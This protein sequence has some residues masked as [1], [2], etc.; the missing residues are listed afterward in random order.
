MVRTFLGLGVICLSS[1]VA[2][3]LPAAADTS[4]ALVP[5]APGVALHVRLVHTTQTAHGSDTTTNVFTL[6]RRSA[7]IA[8]I[9][10]ANP[11]GTPNLSVL[12]VAA[13]GT[14][15]LA[16][17]PRGAAADADV[18]GFLDGLNLAIAATHGSDAT[19]KA[20]WTALMPVG[21]VGAA[22]VTFEAVATGVA[23]LDF[24]GNG[25]T[26]APPPGPAPSESPGPDASAM[27][28]FPGGRHGGFGGGLPGGEFGGGGRNG[29]S[30]GQ[31]GP[32]GPGG[33]GGY[34]R[35]GAPA[36]PATVQVQGHAT[37]GRVTRMAITITRSVTVANLPY[38]N[39]SS[40]VVTVAK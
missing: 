40:W 30:G 5:P 32:G 1:V 35:G 10:R 2:L 6:V 13:D 27:P 7:T 9:E 33:P 16:E 8:V 15:T 11:D 39:T 31:V 37:A 28:G 38:F 22:P 21:A 17:D 24:N 20:P 12:T 36:T 29:F 26:S 18:K 19:G 4:L 3:A 23:E 14:L 34:R 25:D